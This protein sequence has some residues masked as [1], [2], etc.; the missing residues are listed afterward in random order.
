MYSAY[1]GTQQYALMHVKPSFRNQS[2]LV[3]CNPNLP[4]Q[5]VCRNRL[6]EPN[7][8]LN[9]ILSQPL[10][11]VKVLQS[12]ARL[13]GGTN[14]DLLWLF[15]WLGECKVQYPGPRSN[16]FMEHVNEQS[17]GH[18]QSQV[19]LHEPLSLLSSHDTTPYATFLKGR[20]QAVAV[21]VVSSKTR[22]KM[23]WITCKLCL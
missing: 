15:S 20:M 18:L 5:G 10:H 1:R 3:T 17:F 7:P 2:L 11:A 19:L 6:H 4:C 9:D 21:A 8:T 23:C 12:T 14:V 13:F 16:A 22:Y